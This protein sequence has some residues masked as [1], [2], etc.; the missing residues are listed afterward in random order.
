MVLRDEMC[1]AGRTGGTQR[2]G[3]VAFTMS[4]APL[5]LQQEADAGGYTPGTRPTGNGTPMRLDT[6]G[7]PDRDEL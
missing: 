6:S 5:T 2:S 7:T 4:F 3:D 1:D